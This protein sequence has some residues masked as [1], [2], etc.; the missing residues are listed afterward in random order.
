MIPGAESDRSDTALPQCSHRGQ[1]NGIVPSETIGVRERGCL[2][3]ESLGHLDLEIARPVAVEV[4]A[5]WHTYVLAHCHTSPAIDVAI[6]NGV[7]SIEH[8]TILEEATAR[9]MQEL[10]VFLVPTLQTMDK[11][12]AH[13]E[14]WSLPPEKVAILEAA[15]DNAHKS[16]K[17]ADATGVR[18]ASGSDVVGPWQGRRG[19]ELAIKA[20][21][22]GAHKAILSATGARNRTEVVSRMASGQTRP[23]N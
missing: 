8:G 14:W 7:R 10:G 6:E 13:P 18:V 19:E 23:P 12:I 2:A 16:V 20:K 22:L 3:N 15:R 21:L 1:V 17:L 4:A 9:R 11:L 5:G